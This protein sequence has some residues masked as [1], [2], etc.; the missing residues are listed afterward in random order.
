MYLYRASSPRQRIISTNRNSTPSYQH[1]HS[2]P[3]MCPL[4]LT[5]ARCD[6]NPMQRKA[7]S[8][9]FSYLVNTCYTS[10]DHLQI[11]DNL[12][13]TRRSRECI[14]YQ[15]CNRLMLHRNKGLTYSLWALIW[16]FSGRLCTEQSLR[17]VTQNILCCLDTSYWV[18][19]ANMNVQFLLPA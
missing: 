6:L 18:C 13:P 7:L 3:T 15:L 14:R 2:T 4:S 9:P 16:N 5:H 11:N 12:N 10:S 8:L 19:A 1:I 17:A